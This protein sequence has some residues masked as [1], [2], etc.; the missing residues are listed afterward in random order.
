MR[1]MGMSGYRKTGEEVI[2]ILVQGQRRVTWTRVVGDE[3]QKSGQFQST[4]WG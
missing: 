4:F 2:T 1:V 3:M